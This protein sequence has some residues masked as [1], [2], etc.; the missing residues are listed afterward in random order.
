MNKTPAQNNKTQQEPG[1]PL[2]ALQIAVLCVSLV[3]MVIIIAWP[4]TFGST[5]KTMHHSA[6]MLSMLGM[7]CGFVYGFGFIPRARWLRPLFS[8]PVA[9]GLIMLGFLLPLVAN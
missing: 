7:S 2:G 4:H 1:A 9:L 3:V 8:A 6:A 5:T